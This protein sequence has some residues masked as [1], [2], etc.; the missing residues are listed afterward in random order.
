MS[1]PSYMRD[2]VLA[3]PHPVSDFP[4][5]VSKEVKIK[6]SKDISRDL[7]E[8]IPHVKVS[9]RPVPCPEAVA[10]NPVTS[11]LSPCSLEETSSRQKAFGNVIQPARCRSR[12]TGISVQHAR[13]RKGVKLSITLQTADA[14][15]LGLCALATAEL[16]RYD[17]LREVTARD[18]DSDH[19]A[20]YLKTTVEQIRDSQNTCA[21]IGRIH[22]RGKRSTWL[23]DALVVGILQDDSVVQA[24][25]YLE[26]EEYLIDLGLELSSRQHTH[27]RS[28]GIYGHIVNAARAPRL[29]DLPLTRFGG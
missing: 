23:H 16:K 17:R 7:C 12:Y 9:T 25:L 10:S 1:Q 28:A 19:F 8:D 18:D 20:Q 4:R 15:D 3:Q 5:E 6:R 11:G 14:A 26:G 21:C 2:V 24:L 29:S 27:Y 13:T 22:E